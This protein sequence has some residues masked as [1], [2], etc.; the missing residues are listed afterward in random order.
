MQLLWALALIAIF[1]YLMVLAHISARNEPSAAEATSGLRIAALTLF[2]PTLM[3]IISWYGLWKQKL[4]GWWLAV[5]ANLAVM[6]ILV[7]SMIDDG[8]SHFDWDLAGLT[9]A[10]T[11]IPILLLLPW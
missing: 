5:L 10:S 2:L 6:S 11:I 4:W 9:L 8:W 1:V 7:Y 3:A